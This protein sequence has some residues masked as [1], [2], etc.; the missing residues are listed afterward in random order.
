[1]R[2]GRSGD[3]VGDSMSP[4]TGALLRAV[5][6]LMVEAQ[7][8][9]SS[10]ALAGL[11]AARGRAEGAWMAARCP[12]LPAGT[13]A[14][15]APPPQRDTPKHGEGKD[16]RPITLTLEVGRRT[17]GGGIF[18][19]TGEEQVC[20]PASL[21]WEVGLRQAAEIEEG[22]VVEVDMPRWLAD[23]KGLV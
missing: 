1:M 22:D 12:D 5:A 17:T 3:G 6:A 15:T 19:A 16:W 9:P 18:V 8:D 20:V 14:P 21:L 23:E 7:R 10:K 13:P 2:G 11:R 4:E